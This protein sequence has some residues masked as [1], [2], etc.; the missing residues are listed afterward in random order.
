MEYASRDP[1]V[2]RRP[3]GVRASDDIVIVN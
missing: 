2:A 3:A 1:S